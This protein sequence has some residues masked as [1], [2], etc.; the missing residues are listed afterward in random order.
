MKMRNILKIN[1]LVFILGVLIAVNLLL[2]S[3]KYIHERGSG[4]LRNRVVGGRVFLAGYDPYFFHW[5]QGMPEQW[6]DPRVNYSFPASRLTTTP[7]ILLLSLPFAKLPFLNHILLWYAIQWTAFILIGVFFYKLTIIKK[8]KKRIVFVLILFAGSS[9]WIEHLVVGQMY[10]VYAFLI[11][12]AFF[13]MN[14]NSKKWVYLGYFL[15]GITAALRLP[16]LLFV[17]LFFVLSKR[18][19]AIIVLGGFLVVVFI[20]TAF[21]GTNVWK[22]YLT[23]MSYYANNKLLAGERVH[24]VNDGSFY[25][26]K[27]E[28]L[29]IFNEFRGYFDDESSIKGVTQRVL[30]VNT[31]AYLLYAAFGVFFLWFVK[32]IYKR[33]K[34]LKDTHKVFLVGMV[35]VILA[36]FFLPSARYGYYDIQ[37]IVPFLILALL[38]REMLVVEYASLLVSPFLFILTPSLLPVLTYILFINL[39]R[40]ALINKSKTRIINYHARG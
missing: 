40:A 33:R 20:T 12:V 3:F 25:P 17:P 18:R 8:I 1:K 22:S 30:K 19:E 35:L 4:D 37:L 6:L 2:I 15:V 23:S 28:G 29:E 38:Q 32:R 7:T 13:L 24:F 31:P 9:F 26:L 27:I 34:I 14:Q 16:Y 10:I 21:M 39:A 36:E 11:T 5:Q